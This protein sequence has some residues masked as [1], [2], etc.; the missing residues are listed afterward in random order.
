M[1][2]K[3]KQTWILGV[4]L[5]HMVHENLSEITPEVEEHI[6]ETFSSVEEVSEA[7][8]DKTIPELE[9]KRYV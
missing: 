5:T 3:Q 9:I 8:L 1:T 6:K 4:A 2:D 7:F